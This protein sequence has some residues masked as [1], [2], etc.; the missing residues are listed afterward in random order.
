MTAPSF[1]TTREVWTA[2]MTNAA[3][4]ELDEQLQKVRGLPGAYDLL[5]RI[6]ARLEDLE[7][8]R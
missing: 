3:L 2:Q 6:A 7:G 1:A 5:E 4:A 8:A